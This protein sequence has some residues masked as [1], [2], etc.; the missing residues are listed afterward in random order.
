MNRTLEVVNEK[1]NEN[2]IEGE[3]ATQLIDA[4]TFREACSQHWNYPMEEHIRPKELIT[5]Q[6]RGEWRTGGKRTSSFLLED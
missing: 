4:S 2:R 1:E 3:V 6:K 5:V